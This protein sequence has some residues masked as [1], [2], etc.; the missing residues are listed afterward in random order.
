MQDPAAPHTV[1]RMGASSGWNLV[2]RRPPRAR[3]APKPARHLASV[4]CAGVQDEPDAK[5]HEREPARRTRA[6]KLDR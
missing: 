4:P 2:A 1:R 3:V 6:A 5:P